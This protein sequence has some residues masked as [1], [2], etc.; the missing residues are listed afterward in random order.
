M[1]KL[2]LKELIARFRS[3]AKDKVEPYLWETDD[4][5]RWL[6]EAEAEAALR[7]KLLHESEDQ[8]ICT[9]DLV[10]GQKTYQLSPLLFEISWIQRHEDG[11]RPVPLK[12]VTTD[13]LDSHVRDWRHCREV[14]PYVIQT[15]TGLRLVSAPTTTGKL[16]LEGYRFPKKQLAADDDTPEIHMGH[17]EKLVLWAL[18][19]AFAQPDADGFDPNRS[20]LAEQEF[21]SYFG[22]RP[23]ADLRRDQRNDTPQTNHCYY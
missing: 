4:V 3:D 11:A 18:H 22:A 14:L 13:W 23:D 6:N 15:D 19:R 10:A 20:K 1:A 2:S 8:T 7:R 5:K 17:H 16:L 9:I 12:Q 21:T